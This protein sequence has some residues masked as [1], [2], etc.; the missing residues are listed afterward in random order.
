MLKH[1]LIVLLSVRMVLLMARVSLLL[2]WPV[3]AVV[4]GLAVCSIC[5]VVAE[6]GTCMFRAIPLA[7]GLACIAVSA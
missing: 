1:K 3:S 7:V 5:K 2:E 4:N 6:P